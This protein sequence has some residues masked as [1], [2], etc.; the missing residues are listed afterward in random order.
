MI[1]AIKLLANGNVVTECGMVKIENQV[2][3]IENRMDTIESC[4]TDTYNH[5]KYNADKM[6][7]AYTDIGLHRTVCLIR[8]KCHYFL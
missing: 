3:R 6:K 2:I 1:L 7:G 5:Y 4:Y 8:G